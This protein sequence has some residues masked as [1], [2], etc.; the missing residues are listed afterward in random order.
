MRNLYYLFFLLA[1][2]S[3]ELKESPFD[4]EDKDMD[5]PVIAMDPF[6][7]K[8]DFNISSFATV[9]DTEGSPTC[10]F[11]LT[12]N[13]FVNQQYI[14]AGIDS[15]ER[16]FMQINGDWVEFTCQVSEVKDSLHIKT[17]NANLELEIKAK[18]DSATFHKI[19]Y[20][21]EIIIF[22][23][24]KEQIASSVYGECDC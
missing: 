19:Q 4:I 1:I 15:N 3:C 23:D 16:S 13:A 22:V 12:K 17:S 8:P 24:G 18:K 6:Q 2:T 7:V 21:G 11:S 10:Y 14:Y 5:T 20:R 9:P